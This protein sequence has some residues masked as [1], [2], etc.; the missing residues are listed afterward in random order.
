MKTHI[1]YV[2]P[3]STDIE[4]GYVKDAV[5]NGWG[6]K[7]YDYIHR[8]EDAFKKYLDVK[9]AMATSSCTGS[10]HLGLAALGLGPEDEVILAD[11]NWIATV[12]TKR[13]P[14]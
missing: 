4:F 1:P 10:L 9:Y 2:R 6:N 13:A 7:C 3:S 12:V 5:E 14:I 11:T 8:F